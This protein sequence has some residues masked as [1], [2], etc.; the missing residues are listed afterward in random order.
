[1]IYYTFSINSVWSLLPAVIYARRN[2]ATG[3][4]WAFV[5]GVFSLI[6][7]SWICAYSILTL[8]NSSWLTR[9]VKNR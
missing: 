4:M 1:M 9:E 3:A 6:A 7:L 2:S 5:Y 8:R